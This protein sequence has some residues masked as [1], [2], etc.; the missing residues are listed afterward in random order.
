MPKLQVLIYPVLQPVDMRTPSYQQYHRDPLL[1]N[2]LMSIMWLAYARGRWDYTYLDEMLKNEHT[3]SEFKKSQYMDYL[4]HSVLPKH[5]DYTPTSAE[6]GNAQIWSELQD[7]F[8]DPYFAPLMA[9]D[10]TNLPK[11]YVF[12]AEQDVLRDDGIL[13]ASRLKKAGND[14]TLVHRKDALHGMVNYFPILTE[15]KD[16]N[17]NLLVFIRENL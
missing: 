10:L 8:L 16:A 6:I 5:P 11:S 13:Y 9:K 12:A 4:D 14:V 3:S 7:I 1:T 15:A 2:D 17:D